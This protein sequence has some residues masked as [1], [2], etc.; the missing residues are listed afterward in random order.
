MA[1]GD[2]IYY[3][4]N[5]N[6]QNQSNIDGKITKHKS[7]KEIIYSK[8]NNKYTDFTNVSLCE[9]FV[10][11]I[12]FCK[13][14]NRREM[15]IEKSF[16]LI[17]EKLEI[18]SIIQSQLDIQYMKS[19]LLDTTEKEIIKKS[20]YVDENETDFETYLNMLIHNEI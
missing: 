14:P 18:Q 16:K 7:I 20:N 4:D 9:L 8:Q 10:N 19:F 13:K 11:N 12:V 1:P 3:S 6:I 2:N 17:E 15:M 5:D